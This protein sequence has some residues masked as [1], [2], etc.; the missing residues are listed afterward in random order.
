[1][2][3]LFNKAKLNSWAD[4]RGNVSKDLVHSE[5]V[6]LPLNHDVLHAPVEAGLLHL[7]PGACP[8]EPPGSDVT[9]E[10]QRVVGVSRAD[11]R[12]SNA[13]LGEDLVDREGHHVLGLDSMDLMPL[14]VTELEL[15]VGSEGGH[16]GAATIVHLELDGAVH[17]VE[18]QVVTAALDSGQDASQVPG[19]DHHCDV[20]VQTNH[21]S[22]LSPDSATARSKEEASLHLF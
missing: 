11:A 22:S 8:L 21:E 12:N 7:E 18:E 17:H 10:E 1:M 2:C 16:D 20:K 14:A 4:V 6:H 9:S 3:W 15:V 5:L 19:L 13:G